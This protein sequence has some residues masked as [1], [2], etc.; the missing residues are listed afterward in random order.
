M[1]AI[2][3]IHSRAYMK[4]IK[5][6]AADIS[7]MGMDCRKTRRRVRKEYKTRDVTH[8][9]WGMPV[10]KYLSRC[11]RSLRSYKAAYGQE[12]AEAHHYNNADY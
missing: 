7:R 10:G 12:R 6:R 2:D 4:I 9:V 11:W 5:Q 1:R 8:M 3:V